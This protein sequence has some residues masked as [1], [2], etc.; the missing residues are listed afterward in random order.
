MS[1]RLDVRLLDTARIVGISGS[2]VFFTCWVITMSQ[3]WAVLTLVIAA[4]TTAL[5]LRGEE[6]AERFYGGE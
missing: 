5:F 1:P 6:L 2:A 4:P 3:L